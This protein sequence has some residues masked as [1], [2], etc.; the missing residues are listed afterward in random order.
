MVRFWRSRGN[1]RRR[2][3]LLHGRADEVM[4]AGGIGFAG[5]V[6]RCLI[7][8]PASP[9]RRSPSDPADR[10]TII[11]AYVVGGAAR[12]WTKRVFSRIARAISQATNARRAA[13]PLPRNANGKL[14]ELL[15]LKRV[16]PVGAIDPDRHDS[17]KAEPPRE[18]VGV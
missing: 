16:P 9:K 18:M 4:N 10:T 15:A 13:L 5:G 3:C 14:A 11:K 12:R 1:R 2:I 8:H 17:A 6:E 7:A